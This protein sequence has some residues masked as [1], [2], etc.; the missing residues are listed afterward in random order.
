M[1]IY[2]IFIATVRFEY[3]LIYLFSKFS[4]FILF[5]IQVITT[6]YSAFQ[7]DNTFCF[8]AFFLFSVVRLIQFF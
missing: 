6:I 3:T 8:F 7:N 1:A 2:F 5:W 4:Y